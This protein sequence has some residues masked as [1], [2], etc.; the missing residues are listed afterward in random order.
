M[1]SAKN[2]LRKKKDFKA[3]FSAQGGKNNKSFK[4]G[5]LILKIAE[6]NTKENRFGFIVSQKV[7]KKAVIRNKIKRK[8]REIIRLKIKNSQL[9]SG[10]DIILISLPGIEKISFFEIEKLAEK[11]FKKAGLI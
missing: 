4:E 1:L 10:K 3:I 5:F 6:N 2:R 7:S 9:L 8:L 11:I